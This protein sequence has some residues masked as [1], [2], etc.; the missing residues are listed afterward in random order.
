MTNDDNTAGVPDSD[1][2]HLDPAAFMADLFENAT[3]D[4]DDDSDPEDVR[5]FI[6]AAESGELGPVNPAMEAHVRMARSILE[7]VDDE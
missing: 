2:E 3:F 1:P 4:L 5:E 7:D 6:E